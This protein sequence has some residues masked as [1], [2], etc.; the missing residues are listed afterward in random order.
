MRRQCW[1]DFLPF[2]FLSHKI[3]GSLTIALA[4]FGYPFPS[5][6][7]AVGYLEKRVFH[8]SIPKTHPL[9]SCCLA[10]KSNSLIFEKAKKKFSSFKLLVSCQSLPQ[11]FKC[12]VQLSGKTKKI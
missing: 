6:A 12:K 8:N 2:V 3:F 11:A 5:P 7:S 10:G 9:A 4:Y 1:E